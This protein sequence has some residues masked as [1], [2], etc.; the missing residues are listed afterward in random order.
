M[1]RKA[2]AISGLGV[3][4]RGN[5]DSYALRDYLWVVS[6][7]WPTLPA[8]VPGRQI[9]PYSRRETLDGSRLPQCAPQATATVLFSVPALRLS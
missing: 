2:H 1:T 9:Q 4:L 5:P 7:F 6:N 8:L 3:I